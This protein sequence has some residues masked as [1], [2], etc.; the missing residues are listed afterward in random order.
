MENP[1]N[2][3]EYIM[4][5]ADEVAI[6]EVSIPETTSKQ[7]MSNV[8]TEELQQFGRQMSD[9]IEQLPTY[10]NRFFQAY[11]LPIISIAFLLAALVTLKIVLAIMSAL[12]DIPLVS[13]SFQ[14][15]G[16]GFIIWFI[17]RYL[18]KAST[19]QELAMKIESLKEQIIGESSSETFS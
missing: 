18:V 2:S 17:A 4:P 12:N 7:P 5:A 9:F 10:T 19:R 11:K 1:I 13:A 3:Q 14:S 16:I 15:I 6:E 8:K